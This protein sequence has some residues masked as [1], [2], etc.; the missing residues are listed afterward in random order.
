MWWRI[1]D[2]DRRVQKKSF[3]ERDPYRQT[4]STILWLSIIVLFGANQSV[5]Q[6]NNKLKQNKKVLIKKETHK[7]PK[8]PDQRSN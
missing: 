4:A 8:C 1:K 3:T 6:K 5:I 2:Q 7:R